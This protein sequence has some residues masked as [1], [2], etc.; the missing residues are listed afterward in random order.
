MKR[1]WAALPERQD[2]LAA[3]SDRSHAKDTLHA[4]AV[5]PE[6]PGYGRQ[7][8]RHTDY[9]EFAELDSGMPPLP[10]ESEILRFRY[11]LDTHTGQRLIGCPWS[12]TCCT[13]KADTDGRRGGR[14]NTDPAPRSIKNGEGQRSPEMHW[15]K[16]RNQWSFGMNAR[17]DVDADSGLVHSVKG[18]AANGG[19]VAQVQALP[20]GKDVHV[21]GDAKVSIV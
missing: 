16:K 9:R 8:A 5:R 7:L 6:R 10:D 18:R 12:T 2:G 13:I 21:F 15:T 14:R 19:D 1:A 4:A 20:H 3:V 11:L 17:I